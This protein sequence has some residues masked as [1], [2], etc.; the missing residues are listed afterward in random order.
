MSFI[1]NIAELL[2]EGIGFLGGELLV[3]E[4]GGVVGAPLGKEA[5]D[6]LWDIGTSSSTKNVGDPTTTRQIANNKGELKLP[7][8]AVR[9]P[10]GGYY[11]PKT[12]PL[13]PMKPPKILPMKPI[14]KPKTQPM[15]P[16]TP[17]NNSDRNLVSFKNDEFHREFIDPRPKNPVIIYTDTR[18]PIPRQE[19]ANPAFG[20]TV[21]N[22]CGN[23]QFKA[24][25]NPLIYGKLSQ[26][27]HWGQTTWP[28]LKSLRI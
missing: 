24:S 8:G 19:N 3:P 13:D 25:P 2:G 17:S 11:F 23:D 9:V 18:E 20:Q 26:Q 21:F 22:S 14:K 7:P 12:K 16:L 6:W 1:K 27:P 15:K 4:G 5:V 10:G 28:T